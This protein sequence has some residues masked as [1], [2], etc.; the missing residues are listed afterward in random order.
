MHLHTVYNK[1]KLLKS[2]YWELKENVTYVAEP[3]HWTMNSRANEVTLTAFS[4]T[5]EFQFYKFLSSF[6]N[7]NL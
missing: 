2:C 6:F 4:P 3:A 5:A 1:H 7:E